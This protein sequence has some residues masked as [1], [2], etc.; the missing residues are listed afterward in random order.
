MFGTQE[1]LDV[2]IKEL[3]VQP[4]LNTEEIKLNKIVNEGGDQLINSSIL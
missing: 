4:V 2:Y 3:H 1:E